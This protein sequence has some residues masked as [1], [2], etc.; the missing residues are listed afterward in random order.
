MIKIISNFVNFFTQDANPHQVALGFAMGFFMS[1][2]PVSLISVIFFCF[3]F[4]IK[5]NKTAG[6]ISMFIFGVFS[7]IIEPIIVILGAFILIDL[8]F[9]HNFWITLRNIPFIQVTRFYNTAV[10]GGFITGLLLFFPVYFLTKLVYNKYKKYILS[11]LKNNFIVKA[12]RGVSSFGK[13]SLQ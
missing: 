9:L 11:F 3:F 8:E 12:L 6:F 7:I 4:V 10:M 1:I 13:K 2:Q 5:V